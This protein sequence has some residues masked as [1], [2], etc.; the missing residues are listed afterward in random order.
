MTSIIGIKCEKGLEGVVVVSD[1][2]GTQTRLINDGID[3]AHYE[4]RR[5]ASK[6]LYVDPKR[7]VV[8][9]TSGQT[10]LH[11][12]SNFLS[13]IL[14]DSSLIRKAIRRT[15]KT[16]HLKELKKLNMQIARSNQ[17]SNPPLIRILIAT[18]YNNDSR[19]FHIKL[20]QYT[21]LHRF[22]QHNRKSLLKY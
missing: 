17:D 20:V 19:L 8:I 18:R 21:K 10:N 9:G 6:K 14:K 11:G 5:T 15:V 2:S 3:T 1:F 7:E 16:H 4:R 12:Y 13:K 22:S